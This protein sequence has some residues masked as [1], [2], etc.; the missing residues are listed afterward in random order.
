MIYIYVAIKRR[1]GIEW[2][3]QRCH[4][5]LRLLQRRKEKPMT[6]G[7]EIEA[8]WRKF[9]I[10]LS[11]LSWKMGIACLWRHLVGSRESCFLRHW[12]VHELTENVCV[13]YVGFTLSDLGNKI[14]PYYSKGYKLIWRPK[15]PKIPFICLVRTLFMSRVG[16]SYVYI[17]SITS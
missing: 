16:N 6:Q 2:F 14:H 12:V 7:H 15:R 8:R 5:F 4:S 9:S 17:R 3:I 10:H 13:T 11:I 1:I